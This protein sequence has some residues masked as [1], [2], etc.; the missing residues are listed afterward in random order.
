[1]A[2]NRV[3]GWKLAAFKPPHLLDKY[4][5]WNPIDTD[6]SVKEGGG[7]QERHHKQTT[8]KIKKIRLGER[9]RHFLPLLL[10]SPLF[11]YSCVT[12]RPEYN[13]LILWYC[14]NYLFI[15]FPPHDTKTTAGRIYFFFQKR[16]DGGGGKFKWKIFIILRSGK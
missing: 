12:N 16:I 4:E 14:Y 2:H 1:M 3:A 8:K 10:L 9:E 6:M 11:L 15:Y 7:M 13:D 5:L